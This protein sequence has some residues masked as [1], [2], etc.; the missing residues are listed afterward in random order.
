MLALSVTSFYAVNLL[1]GVAAFSSK[2]IHH[3][4]LI[5]ITEANA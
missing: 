2:K 5:N 4:L 3:R 1:F